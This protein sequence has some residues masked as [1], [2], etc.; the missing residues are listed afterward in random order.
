[1]NKEPGPWEVS[2]TQVMTE[3]ITNEINR[4]ILANTMRQMYYNGCRQQG[5]MKEWHKYVKF[6]QWEHREEEY[7]EKLYIGNDGNAKVYHEKYSW[8][9]SKFLL[10]IRLFV[11]RAMQAYVG[12]LENRLVKFNP[13]DYY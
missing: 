5:M 9:P 12:I 13:E 10:N 2:A 7:H 4:R 8:K 3:D 6:N 1:M 11:D